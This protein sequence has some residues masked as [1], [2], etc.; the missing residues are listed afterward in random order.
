M[1]RF[2][3]GSRVCFVGDSITAQ[4]RYVAHVVD[5][6]KTH[7]P[8]ADVTFYN[9]GISGGTAG[10]LLSVF[11]EDVVP[12]KPT[13]VFIM[14]GVND[15]GRDQLSLPR[16]EERWQ[17]LKAGYEIFKENLQKL[18]NKITDIGAELILL[19]PPPYDEYQECDGMVLKGGYALVSGFANYMK[20]LATEKG[21]LI[22]DCHDYMTYMLQENVLYGDDRVHPNDLGQYHI[23]KFILSTQGFE[24]GEFFPIPEYLEPW[25]EKVWSYRYL[26]AVEHMLIPKELCALEEKLHYIKGYLEREEWNVQ[27]RRES[28]NNFF[29]K[30]AENYLLYKGRQTEIFEEIETLYETLC[31]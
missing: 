15:S 5:Y 23:A 2:P 12:L 27:G 1:S 16:S 28:L 4:N 7:F 24:S 20:Q 18:C 11:D 21:Y 31:F 30:I 29:K 14:L 25:R 13:H 19:T 9:C 10:L 6:Y 26:Y 8:E 22:F 3:D 17:S